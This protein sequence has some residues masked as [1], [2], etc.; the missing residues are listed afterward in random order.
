MSLSTA[1]CLDNSGDLLTK[2]EAATGDTGTAAPGTS[3]ATGNT[4]TAAPD[5]S[6]VSLATAG[7]LNNSGTLLTKTEEATGN[8]G[9]AAPDTSEVSLATAGCLDNNGV[10]LTKTD[11]ASPATDSQGKHKHTFNYYHRHEFA[12]YHKLVSITIPPLTVEVPDHGHNVRIPGHSHSVSIPS[13]TH[14]VTIPDHTHDIVYGIYEGTTA[15][16]VTILVDGNTVPASAISQREIDV[17]AWL[18]KDENGKITRNSW[19]EIQIVPDQ[20]TRIEANLFAQCFIQSV[21]GGDY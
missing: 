2:T 18:D 9:T 16:S 12:H 11:A 20:L 15:R 8:T 6:E 10:L 1:G 19:H 4:G 5:T 17:S 14:S 7:C 13:H 3:A 21:G